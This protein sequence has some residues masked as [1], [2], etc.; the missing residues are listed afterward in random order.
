VSLN[1]KQEVGFKLAARQIKRIP[2]TR[3]RSRDEVSLRE[4][5]A[6]RRLPQFPGL[7]SF[8]L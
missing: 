3:R 5:V 4:R 2:Q 1:G 8:S 6:L 7:S